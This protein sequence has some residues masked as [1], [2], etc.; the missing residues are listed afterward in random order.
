MLY[1][2]SLKS[3]DLNSALLAA[4]PSE[5]LPGIKLKTCS[6]EDLVVHKAFASRT[7][8]W[9]DIEGIILRQSALDWSYIADKL[10]P[11][12]VLVEVSFRYRLRSLKK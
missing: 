12:L 10:K 1:S 3:R 11:L 5:F 7:K 6:A 9:L 4:W 8:D 2:S